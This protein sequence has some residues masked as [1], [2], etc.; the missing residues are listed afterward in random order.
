M[1]AKKKLTKD[2]VATIRKLM[3][4]GLNQKQ[5]YSK[6]EVAKSTFFTFCRKVGLSRYSNVD[7][8][9]IRR[10]IE[11]LQ[12][13]HKQTWGFTMIKAALAQ[14]GSVFDSHQSLYLSAIL[15]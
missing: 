4:N 14:R 12:E 3:E 15:L 7:P 8:D 13:S 6:L 10:T 9:Y 2:H 11:M 5:I 1:P